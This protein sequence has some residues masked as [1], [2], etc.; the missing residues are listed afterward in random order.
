M[1]VND[2]LYRKNDIWQLF[3]Q[4]TIVKF[5]LK[6]EGI[7]RQRYVLKVSALVLLT[8]CYL[9]CLILHMIW[10]GEVRTLCDGQLMGEECSELDDSLS[11]RNPSETIPA[12]SVR[13]WMETSS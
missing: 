3:C 13:L 8:C 10:I 5:L 2:N 4:K 9:I 7:G 1:L 11:R 6:V 12:V